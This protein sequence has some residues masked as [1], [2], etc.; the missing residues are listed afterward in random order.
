MRKKEIIC[1]SM[2]GVWRHYA[3]WNK[4]NRERQILYHITYMWNLKKNKICRTKEYNDVCQGIG[5][6]W[7][8]DQKEQKCD[9]ALSPKSIWG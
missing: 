5:W 1:N 2:D 3:K 7:R 4:S 8:D 6:G 9:Y